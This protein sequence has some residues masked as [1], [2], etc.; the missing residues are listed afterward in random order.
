MFVAAVALLVLVGLSL[1]AASAESAKPPRKPSPAAYRL[2]VS[3]EASYSVEFEG[4]GVTG[5]RVKHSTFAGRSERFWLVR[6]G[7]AA[8]PTYTIASSS[9]SPLNLHIAGPLGFSGTEH[10]VWHGSNPACVFDGTHWIEGDRTADIDIRL[11]KSR[12]QATLSVDSDVVVMYRETGNC[13]PRGTE[14]CYACL[15]LSPD[16]SREA[17]LLP[18]LGVIRASEVK[19]GRPFTL[20]RHEDGTVNP[21]LYRPYLGGAIDGATEGWNYAWT[22]KFTRA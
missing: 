18:K 13:H 12:L 3:F 20:V 21:A 7:T 15:S 6:S 22:L 14:R 17:A 19:F 2:S 10:V 11:F 9:G 8:K 4:P 5:K 16:D 1:A